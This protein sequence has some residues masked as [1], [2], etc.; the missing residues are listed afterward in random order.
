MTFLWTCT[1]HK[2]QSLTLNTNVVYLELV[3]QRTF[4]QGQIHVALP[5]STSLSKLNNLSNLE[6]N[7]INPNHSALNNY[8]YLRKEKNLLTTTFPQTKLFVALS[9]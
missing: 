7:I 4:S 2:G 9:K 5:R 3:K 6:P 1:V 8:E